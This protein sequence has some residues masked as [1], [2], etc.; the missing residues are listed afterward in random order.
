MADEV[1]TLN[2]GGMLYT[3]TRST[4]TKYRDSMLGAM[5]DGAFELPTDCNGHYFIDRDGE[6][7][8]YVLN[9]LRTHKICVPDD[10]KN[11]ELLEAEADYYQIEP[12]LE[13][14]RDMI[15]KNKNKSGYYIEILDFE[16][17][18][19]FYRFYSD[20]P[21]GLNAEL[22]N[23]GLVLTGACAALATLPL[24]EKTLKEL[25]N[26]TAAYKSFNLSSSSCSKM[27]ILHHL[28]SAGWQLLSTAFANNTHSDG[29]YMV[30]K[31]LFFLP[32][33]NMSQLIPESCCGPETVRTVSSHPSCGT[34]EGWLE[35]L[36]TICQHL[37]PATRLMSIYNS[38]IRCISK[39][40]YQNEENFN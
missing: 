34:H 10:Y 39:H 8:R 35:T 9:F 12:L 25:E 21:R 36:R 6:T 3:T 14:V 30:H 18:A 11:L 20:P 33:W 24:P 40:K 16:E 26:V 5:F 32:R 7:F 4:L 1:L 22:K 37:R 17:T 29:S 31:Y 28:H 38:M 19:Y 27:S 2:V 13:I 23:G 15:S